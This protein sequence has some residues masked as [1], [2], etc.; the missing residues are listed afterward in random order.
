M[1]SLTAFRT[2]LEDSF[3]EQFVEKQGNIERWERVNSDGAEI[4][5]LEL[6]LGIQPIH[7]VEVRSGFTYKK[8]RY[9]S[10]LKDFATQNFLRTPDCTGNIRFTLNP[11]EKLDLFINSVYTGKADV[12]HEIAVE[13]QED[14][15]LKLERIDSFFEIDFG[16]TYHL[17]LN[18]GLNTKIN[19]GIK[20]LTNAYQND[21]D[22]GPDRDPAYVYGPIRPRTI[23]VGL[24]TAF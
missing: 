9:D 2:R 16:L 1:V 19:L 5:G 21:L 22:K 15:E 17:S 7:S 11:L 3:T 4:K 6:D 10:P 20:N 12:P 8:N 24:E 13:G 14:P 23:Y 18:N